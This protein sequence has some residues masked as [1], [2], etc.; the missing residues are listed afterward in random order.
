LLHAMPGGEEE[1]ASPLAASTPNRI[2]LVAVRAHEAS[3]PASDLS[4]KVGFVGF[5]FDR[6]SPFFFSFALALA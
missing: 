4:F 5:S 3:D 2:I 1:S 6:C